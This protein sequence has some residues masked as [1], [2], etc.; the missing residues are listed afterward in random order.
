MVV[1]LVLSVLALWPVEPVERLLAVFTWGSRPVMQAGRPLWGLGHS[2]AGDESHQERWEAEAQ[3]SH[4]LEE[5]VRH[6]AVPRTVDP[7]GGVALHAEAVGRPAGQLDSLLVRV[8]HPGI[9]EVGMPVTTGDHYVG[10]VEAVRMRDGPDGPFDDVTVALITSGSARVQASIAGEGDWD[11]G[12]RFVVGGLLAPE[13]FGLGAEREILAV[14]HPS[15]RKLEEGRVLVNEPEGTGRDWARLAN[16]FLLGHLLRSQEL[17]E[18]T[19]E[20][21]LGVLPEVDFE[22]GLYQVL[23]HTGWSSEELTGVRADEGLRG[24]WRTTQRAP[25]VDGAPWREG[26]KLVMGSR[27][28]VQPGAAVAHGVR[29]VG[30][31]TQVSPWHAEVVGPGDTDFAVPALAVWQ[32]EGAEATTFVLGRLRSAG[33]DKQGRIRLRWP[34]TLPAPSEKPQRA[35]LYTGS[36]DPGVPRGLLLGEAEIPPGPGPHTLLVEPPVDS[37]VWS[38]LRVFAFEEARR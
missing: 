22:S 9:V 6:Q 19:R 15:N 5:W 11:Q 35:R 38:N 2:F 13:D 24:R 18:T 12:A 3:E 33:R 17:E 31:V 14:H 37:D 36:G 20:A 30:R 27:T 29:L 34:A 10:L 23:I 28:G 4:A 8:W 7:R 21:L 25:Y 32:T 1:C 26:F 16:G